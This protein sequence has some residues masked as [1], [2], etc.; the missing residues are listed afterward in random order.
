MF[1]RAWQ[2]QDFSAECLLD[3]VLFISS[4]DVGRTKVRSTTSLWLFNN[5]RPLKPLPSQVA[6]FQL[7]YLSKIHRGLI[8]LLEMQFRWYARTHTLKNALSTISKK[9]RLDNVPKSCRIIVSLRSWKLL[10]TTVK[11]RT[12]LMLLATRLKL[13]LPMVYTYDAHT[14]TLMV[15]TKWF[16]WSHSSNIWIIRGPLKK[17]K[18]KSSDNLGATYQEWM[19][20]PCV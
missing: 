12:L 9:E 8:L 4:V 20:I 7:V 16:I 2:F 15:T 11:Q 18:E 10:L 1:N 6:S 3:N 13:F 17:R 5:W 14:T 19:T